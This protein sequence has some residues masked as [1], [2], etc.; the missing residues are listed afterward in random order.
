MIL[1]E[2]MHEIGRGADGLLYKLGE[3]KVAKFQYAREGWKSWFWKISPAGERI[4]KEHEIARKLYEQ[5]ISVPKPYGIF[6]L[7][8]PNDDEKDWAPLGLP[9][10]YPAFVMEYINGSIPHPKYLSYAVQRKIDELVQIE[11]KK[12]NDLH[13]FK[14]EDADGWENTLWCPSQEKI[15][16]IDFTQWEII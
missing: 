14:P 13:L 12:V 1:T 2:N 8:Q 9:C 7:K 3:D 16:L 4:R 5:D 15:Y 11:R 10:K 6:N